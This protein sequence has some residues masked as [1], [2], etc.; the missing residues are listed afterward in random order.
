[1]GTVPIQKQEAEIKAEIAEAVEVKEKAEIADRP[2]GGKYFKATKYAGLKFVVKDAVDG[3]PTTM[4]YERFIVRRTTE[5]GYA[6]MTGYMYTTN[7]SVI[8]QCAK[9]GYI[10]EIKEKEYNK[11]IK[12]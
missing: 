4:R 10:E 3:D 9:R 11:A 2:Q 5:A 7:K 1:M 6:V 8:E 12:R